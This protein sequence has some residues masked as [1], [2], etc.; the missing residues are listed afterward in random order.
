MNNLL[1]GFGRALNHK[2]NYIIGHFKNDLIF[3][4][5]RKITPKGIVKE[6]YWED[7]RLDQP[8][9]KTIVDIT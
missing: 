4:Y 8:S 3:G 7:A 9:P 2:G 6:G 1:N 5:A